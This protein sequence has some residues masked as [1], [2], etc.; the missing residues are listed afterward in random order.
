MAGK[1]ADKIL[2]FNDDRSVQYREFVLDMI[3]SLEVDKREMSDTIAAIERKIVQYPNRTNELE[4]E[5]VAALEGLAKVE[6]NLRI[7]SGGGIP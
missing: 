1:L 6:R 4:A 7:L 2:D 5:K 3:E